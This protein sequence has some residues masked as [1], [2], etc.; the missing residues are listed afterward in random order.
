MCALARASAEGGE[1]TVAGFGGEAADPAFV[2]GRSGGE[3][4]KTDQRA[5]ATG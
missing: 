1:Q 3:E 4:G 5:A 2:R